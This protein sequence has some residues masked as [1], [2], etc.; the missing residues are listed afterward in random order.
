MDDDCDAGVLSPVG[1][2]DKGGLEADHL[3][4]GGDVLVVTRGQS[5]RRVGEC[6]HAAVG[7]DLVCERLELVA[8]QTGRG[9][10][11][12]GAQDGAAIRS[13]S[14][15]GEPGRS[16]QRLGELIG[17]AQLAAFDLV[18]DAGQGVGVEADRIGERCAAAR[19]GT[20]EDGAQIITARRAG[21]ADGF[22]AS[23]E[24]LS[25]SFGRVVLVGRAS[26]EGQ[27]VLLAPGAEPVD[28]QHAQLA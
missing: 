26:G 5:W 21:Q 28:G 4:R 17:V 2:V 23:A 15:G 22:G 7:E 24:P 6:D 14:V 18:G 20:G 11:G 8:A 16:E 19:V 1:R 12:N 10:P 3:D 13:G 25:R 9:F 27:V